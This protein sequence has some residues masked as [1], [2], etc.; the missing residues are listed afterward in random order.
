MHAAKVEASFDFNCFELVNYFSIK[1]RLWT[2]G[3]CMGSR[4]PATLVFIFKLSLFLSE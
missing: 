3:L 1:F 4:P 2:C